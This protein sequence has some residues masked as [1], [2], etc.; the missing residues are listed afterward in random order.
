MKELEKPDNEPN[1][2]QYLLAEG[3]PLLDYVEILANKYDP[4]NQCDFNSGYY[5]SKAL[6]TFAER[7][8]DGKIEKRFEKKFL[9]NK[10]VQETI[11]ALELDI[12]KFWY[13]LLFIFDYSCGVCLNRVTFKESPKEQI[14]HLINCITENIKDYN[15]NVDEVTFDKPIKLELSV[16][17][18]HKIT[19]DDPIALYAIAAICSKEMKFVENGSRMDKRKSDA[20]WKDG[21]FESNDIES[22]SVRIWYFAKMFLTFFEINPYIKGRQKKGSTVSLNKMLLISRLVYI[23]ELSRNK[24][25]LD[26]DDTLKGYLKQYKDYKVSSNGIY[27]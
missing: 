12:D 18:K 26:S 14:E 15:D 10:E 11:L 13:L 21:V 27:L 5:I 19:V 23:A 9:E 20:I 6:V 17:G 3:E 8:F 7:C 2:N 22:N 16:Q 1:Y 4:L 24:N 25:F